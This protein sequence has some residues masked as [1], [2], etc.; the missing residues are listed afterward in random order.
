M[1]GQSA[2]KAPVTG[3]VLAGGLSSRLGRDKAAL[4][5]HGEDKALDMLAR[6]AALLKCVCG[7]V[8]IVGRQI[9]GYVCY[10]D[11]LPGN[12]PLGGI[13]TALQTTGTACLVLSCDLP[14]MEEAVLERLLRAHEARPAGTLS[15]AYKQRETGH[16]ESLV[17]IYEVDVLPLFETCLDSKKLKIS[18]ILSAEQQHFLTYSTEEALPFFNINYPADLKVA[19]LMIRMLGK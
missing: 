6:S 13:A 7:K 10:L 1:P 19:R 3:V 15:T 5:L 12:G 8:I 11:A 9:A 17:A 18:R 2:A 16:I 4:R 14:F